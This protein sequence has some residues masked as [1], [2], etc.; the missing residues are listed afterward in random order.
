MGIRITLNVFPT[1]ELRS[2]VEPYEL[3][4]VLRTLQENEYITKYYINGDVTTIVLPK[5]VEVAVMLKALEQIE[6]KDETS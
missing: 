4:E 1:S 6:G 5:N 3:E 2:A